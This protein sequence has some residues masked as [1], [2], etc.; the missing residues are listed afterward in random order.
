MSEAIV[1]LFCDMVRI[2]SESGNEEKF[3][4]YLSGLLETEL[5]AKCSRDSYGNLVAR[6]AAKN[7][8]SN[9]PILLVA[10]A[11]TVKPGVG[12]APKVE[13]G[14]ISSSGDTIL[15]ADDKAGIAEIIEGI[16]AAD[17]HPPLEIAITKSEETGLLGSKNLDLGLIKSKRGFVVDGD[18]LDAIIIGGPSYIALD[19]EITGKAAHAGMEPEK[20]ISA[21]K[22]AAKALAEMPEG[23]IDDETTANMGIINGGMIRNSVPEVV[24]VKGE[25]RSLNHEKCEKQAQVMKTAFE[26]AAKEMG[27]KVDI[28]TELQFKAAR[29]SEDAAVVNLAKQAVTAAGLE[30]KAQV[31]TGGTDALVLSGR[32][33]DS[34]VIGFGGKDAHTKDEHIAV[35]DMESGARVIC[36]LLELAAS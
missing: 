10:H 8:A 4:D 25:C 35:A 33:I 11:D 34:V 23:R 18:D 27:A 30:P 16:K 15:G 2:D 14:V 12:I 26:K 32:G 29:I 21:I 36:S 3:I 9:E 13:G 19:V 7:S 5:G 20:G 24:S 28:T 6:I 31:I 22:V 17:R 1:K